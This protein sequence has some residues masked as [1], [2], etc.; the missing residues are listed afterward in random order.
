MIAMS[1]LEFGGVM[2]AD[3]TI[4]WSP[5]KSVT[6]LRIGDKV[7][8]SRKQVGTLADAVIEEV[9]KKFGG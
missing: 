6:G 9:A 7:A 1:V 4:K 5:E 8:L 3:K 2:T